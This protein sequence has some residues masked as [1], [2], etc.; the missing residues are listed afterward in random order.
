[1]RS[2]TIEIAMPDGVADAYLTQPDDGA[3]HPGVLLI[4]D[5]FGLRPQIEQ[6]A[7][8]IA[9]RG[10]TVLAPNVFYRDGRA[11]PS[12][13]PD[14]KDASQRAPFMRTLMPRLLSLT[15]ERVAADG[16]AY[17][18][19][20]EQHADGPFAVTGYCMGGRV[21]WTIA[22]AHPQRVA[23]LGAFHTGRLVTDEP[24]SLHLRAGDIR[25][26]LYFGHADNDGSM[27]PDNIATL[28]R[29]LDAA[30]ATYRSEVYT[31]APHGYTMADTSEYDAAAAERHYE[32]LFALL[33]RTVAV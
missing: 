4:V 29:A 18:D 1:M 33:G 15:P 31:G 6:M 16:G 2:E 5:A 26:E 23:A 14:L 30:G 24:D 7:D 25:A 9:A 17:L 27:T 13:L 12:S 8:R 21:G 32:A 19:A 3:R 11:D 20:L 28:E 10:L 22:A